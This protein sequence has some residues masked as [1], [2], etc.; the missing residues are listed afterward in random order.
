[1]KCIIA[2]GS[3]FIFDRDDLELVK[4]HTWSVAK[5]HIRTAQKNKSVYL[6]SFLIEL[7]EGQE[8]DYINRNKR[9]VRRSNL[10]PVTRMQNTWN[11]SLRKDSASG[12]RGVCYDKRG[13]RYMAYINA[14]KTRTYLGYFNDAESAA[15]A[16]DRAALKMHGEYAFTNILNKEGVG[17]IEILELGKK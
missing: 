10:R 4:K 5:G 14:N 15:L 11:N 6:H 2:D 12:Y 7:P 17:D 13:G 9:D 16:Y 8:V 1:M 3:S